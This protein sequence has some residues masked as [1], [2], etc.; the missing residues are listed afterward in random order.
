[1]IIMEKLNFYEMSFA[2]FASFAR[3]FSAVHPKKGK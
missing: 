2:L 1:M 3:I